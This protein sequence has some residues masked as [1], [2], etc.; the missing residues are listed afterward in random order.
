MVTSVLAMMGLVPGNP[1]G[2]GPPAPG[3]VLRDQ[4]GR[5][6]SLAQFR[7]K[8]VLL[9]FLD[10]ECTQL[11]PLTTESMVEAMRILGQPP[12]WNCSG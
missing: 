10:P 3:F 12:V 6:T 8:V 2:L 1:D 11:C 9:T 5:L 7:G 4:Q